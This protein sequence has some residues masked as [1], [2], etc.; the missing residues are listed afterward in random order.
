MADVRDLYQE[1]IFEHNKNPRNFGVLADHNR[2]AVGH[3]PLCG[4]QLT[5]YLMVDDNDVVQDVK[6]EGSGCAISVA[7]ASLMTQILKGKSKQEADEFFQA[8]HDVCTKERE[9]EDV[10]DLGKLAVLTGVRDFPSRVKCA[11]LAWHTV[12]A[13]LEHDEE[14]ASVTTE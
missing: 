12:H 4:D 9:A 2:H 8:F 6:F 7:S 11:T 10:P 5:V 13:A 1:V 3:N 14:G